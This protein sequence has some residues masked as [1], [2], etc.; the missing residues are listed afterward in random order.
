M[1]IALLV[2]GSPVAH[3]TSKYEYQP[4]AARKDRQDYVNNE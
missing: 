2:A 4:K 1:N 3:L